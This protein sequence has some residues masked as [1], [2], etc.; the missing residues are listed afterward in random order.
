VM[1]SNGVSHQVVSDDVSGVGAIMSWL[2]YCPKRRGAPLPQIPSS[3][4]VRRPPSFTPPKGAPYDPR[5]MLGGFFDKGSFTEVMAD[6][7]KSVVAG[8]ACLGGVPLGLIA[9]ETRLSEK[10]VPADP[11]FV[12]AQQTVEQ[13]AGQVWFP[14]SAFKTAQAITDFNGE[15][16]PLM[17]FANWRGFAGGLRDMFGEVLKFGALIVDALREYRQPVMVYIPPEGE[18]RGGA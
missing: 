8:R 6:W 13:Q 15:G 7:G 3:D 10:V 18:L 2:A 5:D 11:A 12:G 9:V 16:L 1:F 14:D 4:P 17:V